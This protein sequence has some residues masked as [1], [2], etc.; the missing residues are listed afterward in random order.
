MKIKDLIKTGICL[1]II[2]IAAYVDSLG[3][4]S[5]SH[6][7]SSINQVDTTQADTT[8]TTHELQ[9]LI[10]K[11]SK[12]R[13]LDVRLKKD[14][15]AD[16]QLLPTATWLDPTNVEEWAKVLPKDSLIVVYCVHGHKVSQGVTNRLLE[17]GYPVQLLSG[18]IEAWKEMIKARVPLR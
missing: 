16:P 13:I 3:Q 1:L 4:L 18:G 8:I 14:F 5:H 2:L 17:L 9:E 15:Q 7:K 6:T 12:V 11:R 10:K